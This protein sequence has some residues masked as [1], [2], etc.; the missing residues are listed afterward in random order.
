MEINKMEYYALT[1]AD[2]RVAYMC[3][4]FGDIKTEVEKYNQVNSEPVVSHKKITEAEYL[5]RDP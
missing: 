1:L 4:I 2:Q 3:M 5:Q